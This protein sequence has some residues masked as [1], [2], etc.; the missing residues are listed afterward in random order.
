MPNGKDPEVRQRLAELRDAADRLEQLLAD[1]RKPPLVLAAR[2][3]VAVDRAAALLVKH[4]D[5]LAALRRP[6]QP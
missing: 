4:A 2:A 5:A 1:G 3:V 6:A